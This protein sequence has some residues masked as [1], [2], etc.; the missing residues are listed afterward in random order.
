MTKKKK[1]ATVTKI[2]PPGPNPIQRHDPRSE[3]QKLAAKV[4]V[5]KTLIE[6]KTAGIEKYKDKIARLRGEITGLR[7]EIELLEANIPRIH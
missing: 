1:K 7:K 5:R 6:K 4:E 3:E 2:Y